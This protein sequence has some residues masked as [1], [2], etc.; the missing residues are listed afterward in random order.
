MKR[1]LILAGL[2]AAAITYAVA[3]APPEPSPALRAYRVGKEAVQ[4]CRPD[5]WL[6]GRGLPFATAMRARADRLGV[7]VRP[8]HPLTDLMPR[9][10][11]AAC[12]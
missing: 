12:G 5:V 4:W 10:A 1:A 7:E 9:L 8:N 3:P 6:A 2:S 11:S